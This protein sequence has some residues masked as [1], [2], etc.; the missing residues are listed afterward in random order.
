MPLGFFLRS[1]LLSFSLL[2]AFIDTAFPFTNL[3]IEDTFWT[4]RQE[5]NRVAS[6]PANLDNLEKA[7]NIRNFELAAKGAREG[8]SG[9]VFMDSDLYKGLEAAAYSLSPRAGRGQG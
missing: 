3:Q 8:F 2:P 5:T 1:V 9:P 6:I 7:G 4:P